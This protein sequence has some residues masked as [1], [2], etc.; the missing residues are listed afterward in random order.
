[1]RAITTIPLLFLTLTSGGVMA[2]ETDTSA[3]KEL[4]TNN[5]TECH[6]T[7]VYTRA[8]RRVKTRAGLS[9][10]VQRCEQTLGLTWF[11][12]DVENAAEFL[13]KSYYHFGK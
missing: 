6:G 3:G 4:V 10:Q 11:E 13:N 2:Q 7:E 1:M 8:E 12:E 5:C 9:K